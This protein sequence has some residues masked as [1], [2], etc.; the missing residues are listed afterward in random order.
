MG[1]DS[2][3]GDARVEAWAQELKA[4]R[5][6]R[7]EALVGKISKPLQAKAARGK[8]LALVRTALRLGATEI[9]ALDAEGAILGVVDL[10]DDEPTDEEASEVKGL[11]S[12]HA[13]DLALLEVLLKA[14]RH[15]W[16][17]VG[18]ILS[19]AMSM[20]TNE[21]ER[22]NREMANR[23]AGIAERESALVELEASI[24]ER[25]AALVDGAAAAGSDEALS[26][27]LSVM[28]ATKK[29]AS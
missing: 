7:C 19:A 15:T 27:L 16:E 10:S 24:A 11:A 3:G 2:L 23:E 9:H 13:R 17:Q 20:A 22:A 1:S 6:A 25:E 21:R 4:M 18:P 8:W 29:G 26:K 14:Q 12:Q 5:P 28:T